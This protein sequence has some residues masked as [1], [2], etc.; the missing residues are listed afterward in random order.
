MLAATLTKLRCKERKQSKRDPSCP[1]GTNKIKMPRETVFR[2]CPFW[3]EPGRLCLSEKLLSTIRF[4]KMRKGLKSDLSQVFEVDDILILWQISAGYFKRFVHVLHD[5]PIITLYNH[6]R[7]IWYF[8]ILPQCAI[9]FNIL[10]MLP[11]L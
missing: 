5:V 8:F 3:K 11:I 2:A 6:K 1:E 9:F 4:K 7:F 10:D